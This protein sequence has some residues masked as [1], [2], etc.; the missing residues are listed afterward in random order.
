MR[1]K[2]IDCL[3]GLAMFM[4]VYS[5][6]MSFGMNP[7]TPSF[8]GLWMRETM[9]PLFFFISGFVSYKGTSIVGVKEYGRQMWKKTTT[10]L[11][12]TLIMMG[13]MMWYSDSNMLEFLFRYDKAGF[14]FTMVLFQ[15]F[16][17]YYPALILTKCVD[18][19]VVKAMILLLP[20]IMMMFVFRIVGFESHA[21]ILFEWVK[22][23]GFYLFFALGA[24]TNLLQKE[25]I[26]IGRW[27]L[28]DI[29]SAIKSHIFS[30]LLIANVFVFIR[31]G[32]G[33]IFSQILSVLTL[34]TAFHMLS[35][36]LSETNNN[37][38]NILAKIGCYTL[39][40]YLMHFF[41]LFR[42]PT[43][44]TEYIKSLQTDHCFS[45][46]SC[47]SLVEFLIV[48]LTTLFICYVC[49]FVTN[50]LNRAFP[51]VARWLLGIN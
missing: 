17:I 19:S 7:Y 9:L 11:L 27:M 20:Y 25:T 51:P 24:I 45:T 37:F 42:L 44:V 40:I 21:A 28:P 33:N 12:P 46:S 41:L 50:L 5:H 32:G 2:Y 43:S 29:P 16:A 36:W 3:R 22:V 49:I 38:S 4:V 1:L 18:N 34:Y 35:T 23:N 14:W 10:M 26:H 13:L 47:C 6:V 30:L 39:P 15:I 8:I 48:G 31:I